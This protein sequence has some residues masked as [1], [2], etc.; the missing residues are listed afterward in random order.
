MNLFVFLVID[1]AIT[2]KTNDVNFASPATHND[3][4]SRHFFGGAILYHQTKK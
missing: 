2:Q 3:A 1:G 4:V